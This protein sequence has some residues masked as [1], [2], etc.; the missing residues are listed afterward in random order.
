[1]THEV[2]FL[3]ID[4]KRIQVLAYVRWGFTFWTI[5]IEEEIRH[6]DQEYARNMRANHTDLYLER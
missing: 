2:Y 5:Y 3:G 6:Y 1:M 4:K